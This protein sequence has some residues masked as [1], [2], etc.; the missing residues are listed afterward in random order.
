VPV[1]TIKNWRTEGEGPVAH[2]IGN[3]LRYAPSDVRAW[4]EQCH[5]ATAGTAPGSR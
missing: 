1:K 2:K 3:H 5:E 4:L